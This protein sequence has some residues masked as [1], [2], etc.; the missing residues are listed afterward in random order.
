MYEAWKEMTS[1]LIRGYQN[2]GFEA[3]TIPCLYAAGKYL[4]VFA[5][6]ADDERSASTDQGG[7][8]FGDDFDPE[9]EAHQLLEDCARQLNRIFNLCLNDRQVLSVLAS[10][11]HSLTCTERAW[12]NRENGAYTMSS[13]FFSRLTS[14]STK[15]ACQEIS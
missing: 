7:A 13:T 10:L 8:T 1:L 3:W 6:K 15:P 14:S 12:R 11:A 5:I 4:R 9:M 2:Y